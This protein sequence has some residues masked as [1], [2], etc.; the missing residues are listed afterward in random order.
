MP[1]GTGASRIH[2]LYYTIQTQETQGYFL[3]VHRIKRISAGIDKSQAHRA[4]PRF[5]R[6]RTALSDFNA[7]LTSTPKRRGPFFAAAAAF[8]VRLMRDK[9]TILAYLLTIP[10]C[11]TARKCYNICTAA[12]G[13]CA[14]PAANRQNVYNSPTN[15]KTQH[16][17]KG[18]L[19]P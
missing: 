14:K 5:H 16:P 17:S 3:Y 7:S 1:P 19:P 15:S 8:C 13:A 6:G 11:K 18:V 2:P 4:F 9:Q 10:I 12:G